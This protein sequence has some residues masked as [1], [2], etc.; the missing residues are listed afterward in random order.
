[1]KRKDLIKLM[2]KNGWYFKRRGG[3]HDIYTDGKNIEP[4][5]RQTEIKESVAQAIIRR[6]GLKQPLALTVSYKGGISMKKAYPIVITPEASGVS[7]Y[8]PDFDA[9][10]QGD[11]IAHGI[12]MARDAIGPAWTRSIIKAARSFP[13][14]MQILLITGVETT[15]ALCVKIALSPV[16]FAMRQKRLIL[17]FPT[18]CNRP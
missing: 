18:L 1:M 2:E 11:D 15:C 13:W 16:G 12:E 17:I 8:I 10:T 3:N 4:I 14:W 6:R 9:N 7:V 5:S